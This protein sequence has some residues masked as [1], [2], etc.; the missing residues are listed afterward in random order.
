MTGSDKATTHRNTNTGNVQAFCR[1][2]RSCIAIVH[3]SIY[4]QILGERISFLDA[5]RLQELLHQLLHLNLVWWSPV[6]DDPIPPNYQ[7]E[8][9]RV[10][11]EGHCR[12]GPPRARSAPHVMEIIPCCLLY[13]SPSPRDS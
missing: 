12:F 3:R 6:V 10:D 11:P 5:R 9:H 4:S 1:D 13:T 8:G 2:H 7:H